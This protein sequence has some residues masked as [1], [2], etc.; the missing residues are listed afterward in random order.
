[1]LSVYVDFHVS[2]SFVFDGA[3]VKLQVTLHADLADDVIEK[4]GHVSQQAHE[5]RC[6]DR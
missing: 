2:V 1:M 4:F 5:N 3:F 6:I